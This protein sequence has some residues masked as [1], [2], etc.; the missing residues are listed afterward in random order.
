MNYVINLYRNIK[1]FSLFG[2]KRE[3][4]YFKQKIIDILTDYIHNT[5]LRYVIIYSFLLA[6]FSCMIFFFSEISLAF[7]GESGSV[8]VFFLFLESKF[9]ELVFMFGLSDNILFF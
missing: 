6:F 4:F 8:D 5:K 3:F 2:I 9:D 1:N 7:D